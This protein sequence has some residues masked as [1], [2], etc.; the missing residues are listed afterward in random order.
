MPYGGQTVGLPPTAVIP[1]GAG[2]VVNLLSGLPLQTL[3]STL[4]GLGPE[5]VN[6][7]LGVVQNPPG[8]DLGYTE[9]FIALLPD[10]VNLLPYELLQQLAAA[11]VY[12]CLLY[13]SPSPRDS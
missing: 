3:L 2:Q 12:V 7:V 5:A 4:A 9:D 6:L 10:I 8:S 13:T 1:G 11:P